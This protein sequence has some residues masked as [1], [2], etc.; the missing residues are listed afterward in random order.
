MKKVFCVRWSSQDMGFTFH[1][2]SSSSAT[3]FPAAQAA[4][5]GGP[6]SSFTLAARER[7]I[8]AASARGGLQASGKRASKSP[9]CK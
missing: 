6:N 1:T 5:A 2:G 8:S 4:R 3:A 7:S 9:C